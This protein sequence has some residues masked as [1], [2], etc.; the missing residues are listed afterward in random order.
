MLL[1]LCSYIVAQKDYW[2]IVCAKFTRQLAETK[3]NYKEKII[4]NVV[5]TSIRENDIVEAQQ[6]GACVKFTKITRELAETKSN[7]KEQIIF[8]TEVV[9]TSTLKR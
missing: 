3:S 7:Y 6:L 2:L 8:T 1:R 9:K 5:K 4:Y